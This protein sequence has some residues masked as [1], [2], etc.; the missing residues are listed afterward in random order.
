MKRSIYLIKHGEASESFELRNDPSQALKEGQIRVAVEASGLNFAD[1]MA[2]RGLYKPAPKPPSVLGYDICGRIT[3]CGEKVKGLKTG[4]RVA[5]ITLF[6]GYTSEAVI[7]AFS[8]LKIDEET[9]KGVACA[10]MTQGITAYIASRHLI[11]FLT[12]DRILVHAAAGG[13][14]SLITQMAKHKGCEVWGTASKE[15]HDFIRENGVDHP[16]D[17]RNEDFYAVIKKECPEGLDVVFD[18]LGGNSFKKGLKLLRPGG[19]IVSYGAANQNK[20]KHSGLLNTLKVGL[21][22]GFYSPIPFIQ[23]SQSL[24][25]LNLLAISKGRPERQQK[26]MQDVYRLYK[27]GIL[28]PRA[29]HV[30]PAKEVGKAHVFMEER[31]SMGKIILTWNQD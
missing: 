14:G 31:K 15:K 16:V 8:A 10:L 19:R 18:N 3:A 6:G 17:Y 4:D 23:K 24:I 7:P 11:N 21:G 27:E 28:S 25:G 26:F 12:G 20:G 30:F 2:R 29:D 1:V 5:A 9:P 22:F 13:V